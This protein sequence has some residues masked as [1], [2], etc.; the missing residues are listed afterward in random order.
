MV[1]YFHGIMTKHYTPS[2]SEIHCFTS[3]IPSLVNRDQNGAL[4]RPITYQEV[5]MAIFNLPTNKALGPNGFTSYFFKVGWDF[6]HLDIYEV[7]EESW[8]TRSIIPTLNE[9]FITFISKEGYSDEPNGFHPITP[10]NVIY[11]TISTII[12]SQ[13]MIQMENNIHPW[14]SSTHSI[15]SPMVL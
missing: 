1:G 9:T 8:K 3:Y 10:C 6:H 15:H 12:T 5:Q 4:M 7:V 13:L 11:K 2:Q 14:Y